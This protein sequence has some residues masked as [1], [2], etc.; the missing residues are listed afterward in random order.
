MKSQLRSLFLL[1]LILFPV[2]CKRVTDRDSAEIRIAFLADVHLQDVYGD[3]QDSD[4]KGIRNP[5]NG[6]YAT[7]RTMEAQLHSTRLFNE[8]YFAFL[9]ALDDIAKRGVRFVVL[10]GD[11]SDDGQAVNIRGLKK[12][13]DE[14]SDK[15]GITFFA[16][17]GN[18]DP[19]RPFSREAGKSDY[20][21]EGGKKQALL[22]SESMKTPKAAGLLPP[23]YTRD[24]QQL[25]YMEIVSMLGD[26]GFFPREEDLYWETPFSTYSPDNYNFSLATEESVLEKRMYPLAPKGNP[27][28]DVSYLVEPV[29]GLWLLA[30]DANVYMPREGAGSE[31]ENPNSYSGAGVG[32][33]N[34][35]THKNHL[36]DWVGEVS[37]Q[38]KL[39]DKT[40]I[41][42]SHY[43]MVDFNDDASDLIGDLLGH[44]AMQLYRLPGEEVAQVFADAGIKIHFGGHM[45]I[46]DTGIRTSAKG[47]TLVNVQIPSLAAYIP[48]YKLL[49]LGEN[50]MAEVET[51]LLDSVPRY[52]EMFDLYLQEYNY[53]Q[54]SASPQIWDKNILLADSYHEFTNWHLRELVR[55][56]FLPGEWPSGLKEFMLNLSGEELLIWAHGGQKAE[57]RHGLVNVG[58]TSEQFREWTGFDLVF[59]FYRLRNADRLA[60]NDIGTERIKQYQLFFDVLLSDSGNKAV[61]NQSTL[62]AMQEFAKIFRKF[63]N[64]AP[65]DHFRVNL[66]SGVLEDL[67]QEENMFRM[68]LVEP[69]RIIKIGEDHYFVDFGKDAFGTVEITTSSAQ[70]DP[71]IVH[72][73]EKLAD[74]Q[75]IDRDPGGTI[76]YQKVKLSGLLPHHR[77]TL[78]LPPDR[79]NTGERAIALPDSFGVIMPFRYCELENLKVP[80]EDLIIKQKIY[81]YRFDEQASDFTSSDTVLNQIWDLFKHTIKATSFTGVYVD[82][83]RERI[84]YEA[85]A[86]INQLSHYSF[87]NEYTMAQRTNEYFM[88]NPTWPT[89]WILQTAILF[90]YDF[91]YTGNLE[92]VAKHYEGLKDKTLIGLARE[93]GLIST[94][95]EKLDG[96]YMAKLGF[97]DS[98]QRIRDI[99][100]WPPG[101]A[102][103]GWKLAT[104]EGERDGYE[105]TEINTVVNSFHYFNLK[106]MAELADHLGKGED[107][108]F[109][110][111]RA[112]KVRDAINEKLFDENTGRYVDGESSSHSSLHANMFPLAFGIVPDK[113]AESV[114]SFVKSRGMAC[115]VYGSQ[116]LLEGLFSYG[117]AEYGISLMNSTSDRSW[118]NMIRIG[119]TMA[120]EA[121]DMKYK[122][123]SDWN[124]AWGTA[125][126]NIITRHLWGIQPLVPGYSRVKIKPQPGNLEFTT[127]KVPTIMGSILASFEKENG[128]DQL[129][130]IELPDGMNGIFVL[131]LAE[132]TE[133]YLNGKRIRKHSGDLPLSEGLT[134]IELRY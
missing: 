11:F 127:I 25:G 57:A 62:C 1:F 95:S 55:Q 20:L 121:W 53:L 42:F 9:A 29:E 68:S 63:L 59:D 76:R 100:D 49:T 10:P 61:K 6:E 14:Y 77:L 126:A 116:F 107:S 41:V 124:H 44:K 12:I 120:L 2:S 38:A 18:H 117:E 72:L 89:E 78:E 28:P 122:P 8:N 30:L 13:L 105:L 114:I 70:A 99:V 73:G 66:I 22:S 33:S 131:P 91:L 47:N 101:Q 17:T 132:G 65:A 103:T 32:Y 21:G 90:Y 123:N 60:L 96:A 15:Y 87:D 108:V 31:P 93:D 81:H 56:R 45:H 84:P 98:S 92:S 104:P 86:L 102:D 79:R 26:F 5:K 52:D 71:L 129:Y 88:H 118:W 69:E 48:A 119:S 85:D 83:D 43:P 27:I 54:R 7:I 24:I 19:V 128:K 134:R 3:F 46:N 111:A 80:I 74:P 94:Y 58:L 51:I 130:V 16:T 34:V 110:Q 112:L 64:G 35:L 115:S 82:G 40:L 4:Y 109:F 106:I 97:R 75:S 113:H 125:P 36:V 37:R 67:S 133:L 23:V 39:L 50:H